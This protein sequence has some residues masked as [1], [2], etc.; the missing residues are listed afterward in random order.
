MTPD[1]PVTDSKLTSSLLPTVIYCL[2]AD[3]IV[4]NLV[5]P[6]RAPVVELPIRSAYTT[7]VTNN[8]RVME[9]FGE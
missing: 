6:Q 2:Y 1:I 9:T 4:T 7:I 3:G 5:G 8:V